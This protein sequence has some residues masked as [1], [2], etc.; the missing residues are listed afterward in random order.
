[1]IGLG[2][3]FTSDFGTV[4]ECSRRRVP[5]PPQKST[6]FIV[7]YPPVR[8]AGSVTGRV[9]TTFIAPKNTLQ[10]RCRPSRGPV[11]RAASRCF[12]SV[13]ATLPHPAGSMKSQRRRV[14]PEGRHWPLFLAPSAHH[15]QPAG[16][17]TQGSQRDGRVDLRCRRW[18]GMKG[19]E[20]LRGG[21]QSERYCERC[22]NL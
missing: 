9:K 21:G 14:R 7:F 6:T 22:K 2:P 19:H 1:M 5:R 17:Q 3:M 16:Q 18:L 15:G 4:S 8:D 12:K 13:T 11:M 20:S 10:P